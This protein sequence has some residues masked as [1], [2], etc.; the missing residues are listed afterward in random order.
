MSRRCKIYYGLVFLIFLGIVIIPE[1]ARA[2]HLKGTADFRPWSGWWWPK[3]QGELVFGYRGKPAPVEKYGLYVSGKRYS[4]AYFKGLQEWYD[5]NALGWE[6]MCNGWVNASILENEPILPASSHG[7]FLTVGDKKGLLTACHFKDE[8]QY[9]YCSRSPAPFHRY[10]LKYIGEQGQIIGADLDATEAFWS[11][12]IYS[13]EMSVMSGTESDTVVCTIKYASDFVDPDYQGS[14]EKSETYRYRLYKDSEGNY[15][16]QGEWLEESHPQSVWV[17]IGII[18]DDLFVDYKLVKEMALTYDDESEGSNLLPGHHL[19]MIYP[20]E[21][22]SF[23]ITP[24]VGETLKCYMALDP[25]SAEGNSARYQLQ[26]NQKIVASGDL[27]NKLIPLSLSSEIGN[28][29]LRLS[30]L[31]GANNSAGVCVHLYVDIEAPNERWFYGFP[32]STFWIGCAA[33]PL[34]NNGGRAWLEIVGDQGLPVGCGAVSGSN[35]IQGGRWLSNL[36]N[37]LTEDYFTNDGQPVS[38]KLVSNVP[39]ENL[40]LSGN[41]Q[42]LRGP[43]TSTESTGHELII[44]WL[45]RASDMKRSAIF[46]LYNSSREEVIAEISYFKSDGSPKTIVPVA[47]APRNTASF[48]S[49]DYPGENGGVDGWAIIR[50]PDLKIS[51]ATVLKEGYKFSDQLPLLKSRQSWVVPHLATTYGWQSRLGFCNSNPE[52]LQVTIKAVIEGEVIGSAYQLS[53]DPYEKKELVVSGNLFALSDEQMD[54]A[55]LRIDGNL[56]FAA[57]QRYSF[58]DQ[59]VASMALF[60]NSSGQSEHKLAHLVVADGWWTGIVLLN[61]GPESL[62]FDLLALDERGTVLQ[63]TSLNLGSQSKYCVDITALFSEVSV[64]ALASLQLEGSGLE[65]IKA[66]AIYG[67][68]NGITLLSGHAW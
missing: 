31:P 57:Y 38:F 22:D 50:S 33:S 44:P 3:S 68:G 7:V 66:Q 59:S 26:C 17:P 15:N 39:C 60:P 10:L 21:D 42:T 49:G 36:D 35:F 63:R 51:G 19:L 43:T 1:L 30:F 2:Q 29:V 16:G 18:Q 5:P 8:I 46:Y 24:Q 40:L 11:Y 34:D 56:K 67:Y 32:T 64:R 12:P 23:V 65:N 52:I 61:C 4:A 14:L 48:R 41:G 47:L 58:G 55:W 6:G 37:H 25:Q 20:G 13:Y 27:D 53:L 62:Q 54:Q 9:E 28:D 45:T